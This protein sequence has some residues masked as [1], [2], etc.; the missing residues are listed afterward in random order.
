MEDIVNRDHVGQE[1]GLKRPITLKGLEACG[2]LEVGQ[3]RAQCWG[4]TAKLVVKL[5]IGA[6]WLAKMQGIFSLIVNISIVR[7]F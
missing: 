3:V 4:P 5:E 2:K 6:P 1:T 7:S